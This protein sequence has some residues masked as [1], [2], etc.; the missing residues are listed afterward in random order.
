[1]LKF[2]TF[3]SDIELPFYASLASRKIDHDKLDDSSRRI[4]G[5]YEIKPTDAPDASCRLQIHGNSL[6]SDEYA[7][8][9]QRTLGRSLILCIQRGSGFLP[10]G[11]N[12]QE[13][14]YNRGLSQPG[15]NGNTHSSWTYGPSIENCFCRVT[16]ALKAAQIWDAIRDGTIYSCPSLLASFIIICFADLKKYKFTYLF[17]FPALHS[18]PAWHPIASVRKTFESIESSIGDSNGTIRL[19]AGESTALVES[20]QT[21]RY[22]VDAR[23]YGFFLAKKIREPTSIMKEGNISDEA[24][25]SRLATP[26]TS[27]RGLN[28]SWVVGSLARY[29]GG[30]FE[31]VDV[32]DQF[33]CF[34]DPSTYEEYPGWMLRN[35]LVLVR[36]RWGLNRVQ[37]L[38]YRDIQSRREDGRSLLLNLALGNSTEGSKA[39]HGNTPD[40]AMPRVSGWERSDK[41]RISSKIAN[42]GEYMDPRRY[43]RSTFIISNFMLTESI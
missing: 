27:L 25:Q 6:T 24:S 37:V 3:T 34:A 26:E 36:E 22:G 30:F 5:F 2:A 4:L 21:W 12:D 1:M 29:E 17:G 20:V 9:A 33:V 16:Q 43:D 31:G 32:A 42:L 13:C 40:Q 8:L 11:G 14:Q 10:R 41:G 23:Q 38:C 7:R 15:Q 28:F 35:L 19:S 39:D 18:E